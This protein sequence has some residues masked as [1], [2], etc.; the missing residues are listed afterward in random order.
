MEEED[1]GCWL[2]VLLVLLFLPLRKSAAE[3][4]AICA[5]IIT[6][7]EDGDQPA[8]SLGTGNSPPS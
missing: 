5:K 3:D 1:D 8:V 4:L 7:T 6:S 2:E